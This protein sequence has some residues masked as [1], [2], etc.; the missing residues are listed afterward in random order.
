M[1]F[2]PISDYHL[3]SFITAETI[4]GRKIGGPR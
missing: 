4:A 3:F 1:N 2:N